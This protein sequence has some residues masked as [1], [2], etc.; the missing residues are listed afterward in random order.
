MQPLLVDS[1]GCVALVTLNRPKVINAVNMAMRER[2]PEILLELEADE[3]VASI[4]IAGAGER[5]FCAGADIKEVRPE[6]TPVSE[7]KR[8]T[9]TSWI[10]CLDR[11]S[12]PLIAAIHGVCL[13]AG[14]ELALACDFRVAASGARLGLPET[15]LGLIP[16]GGGTQRLPR[17]I[18]T[19]RALD[20]ILT[21]E[22]VDAERAYDIGLVSRLAHSDA[23]ALGE[24]LRIAELIAE[25]A[26]LATRYAKEAILGGQS[27]PLAAGL[28]LEKSL[29]AILVST[30]DRMEAAAAFREKRKPEFRSR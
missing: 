7:L 9:P 19:G 20:M 17:L 8:L 22:A 14:L 28:R 25:R 24:A 5:G 4:V 11:V 29:F 26:P 2:L 15:A 21:G 27:L 23:D 3:S 30:A 18:G 16:G 13:G 12:K 1:R 10:E 6:P